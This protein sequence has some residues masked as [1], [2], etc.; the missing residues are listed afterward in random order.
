MV[1]RMPPEVEV[2]N[3][4]LMEHPT[5]S[6][7]HAVFQHEENGTLHIYDLG[8]THGTFVNQQPLKPREWHALH[9]GDIIRFAESTRILVVNIESGEEEEE[10]TQPASEKMGPQTTERA[11]K[12]KKQIDKLV[13]AAA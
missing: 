12:L 6:R 10:E 5:L 13:A 11:Q 4:I 3:F 2:P 8:S 1:G 9:N 7:Q